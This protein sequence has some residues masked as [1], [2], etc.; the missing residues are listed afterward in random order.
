[1]I[2]E[3]SEL[4]IPQ[5]SKY[6]KIR[7]FQ[8]LKAPTILKLPKCFEISKSKTSLFPYSKFQDSKFK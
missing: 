7:N 4:E 3:F 8:N 2:S 1:M 5:N 6:A